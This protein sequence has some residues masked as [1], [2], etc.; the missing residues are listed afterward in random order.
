VGVGSEVI[1]RTS[2]LPDIQLKNP[3]DWNLVANAMADV[4]HKKNGGYRNNGTAWP[5]IENV[6]PMPYRMAGKSGTAQVVG[7]AADFD[8]S[9]EVPE[10]YRDHALFISFAPV[11]DP[12]IVV[13]VFVEHGEGGS[14]VA[15]PIAR[16]VIDSYIMED[17]HI[18]PEFLPGAGNNSLITSLP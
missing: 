17:G 5:Y 16:K 6:G 15:G 14:S 2:Y 7:M 8:N 4:V 9:A 1:K 13:A 12:K 18:K 3:D 10:K 11:D